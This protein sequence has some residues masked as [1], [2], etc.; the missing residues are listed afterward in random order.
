MRSFRDRI[1][2]DGLDIVEWWDELDYVSVK[3]S[4]PDGY[5]IEVG[6]T[7]PDPAEH[8]AWF[9]WWSFLHAVVDDALA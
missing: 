7:R 4:D 6:G 3:F 2:A 1:Q 5:V 9:R 8:R